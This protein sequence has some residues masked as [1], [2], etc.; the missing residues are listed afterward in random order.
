MAK[1]PDDKNGSLGFEDKLWAAA[2]VLRDAVTVHGQ[3]ST[4]TTRRMA[5][6]K[7][8]EAKLGVPHAEPAILGVL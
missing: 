7:M 1:P 2:D 3:E 5:H 8:I 6:M 4:P